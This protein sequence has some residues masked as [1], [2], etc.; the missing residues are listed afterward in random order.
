MLNITK[1]FL[2]VFA[3][4]LMPMF[5]LAAEQELPKEVSTL[6]EERES[7]DHWRGEEGYDKERRAEIAWSICHSCPGTDSKLAVLK[8]KYRAV[9]MDKLAKLEPKIEP[10][11]KAATMRFCRSLKKPKSLDDD[12]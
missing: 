11:D 12:Q 7:C 9:T 6:L 2:A 8:K 5:C 10:D 3:I 4:S 1:A